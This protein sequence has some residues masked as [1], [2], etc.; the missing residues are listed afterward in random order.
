VTSDRSSGPEGQGRWLRTSATILSVVLTILCLTPDPA[1][2]QSWLT[3]QSCRI[4]SPET[5]PGVIDPAILAP[6]ETEAARI[7]NGT[8]R[9]W[10]ITGPGGAV[11]H[12]W[13][14]MHSSDPLI[15]NLPP[16]LRQALAG[17]QVVALEYDPIYPTRHAHDAMIRGEGLYRDYDAPDDYAEIDPRLRHWIEARL[18]AIGWG[19]DS[20][21]YLTEYGLASTLLADPCDDFAAGILPLQDFRI[22][23]LGLDA[24]A[25]V[26][27]LEPADAIEEVLNSSD[28]REAALAMINIYGRLLGPFEPASRRTFFGLYLQGRNG[29]LMALDRHDAEA[30]FGAGEGARLLDLTDGY[31]LRERN[32]TFLKSAFPLL[33]QGG[34]VIAVGSFHLPGETGLIE[35][36]RNAGYAVARVPT[37]GEVAGP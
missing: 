25:K 37:R 2:A 32:L 1:P 17:A 8:G 33:K 12:L 18:D 26:V 14:T 4:A 3:P 10:R 34:A 13:G 20:L 11:S 31:L 29:A 7:P 9:L 28:R 15:L 23:L 35:L 6:I 19:A 36:L 16:E 27:G 21:P 22:M 5:D 30:F 24:G